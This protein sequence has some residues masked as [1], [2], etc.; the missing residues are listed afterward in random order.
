[1]DEVEDPE[2]DNEAGDPEEEPE[3]EEAD[4]EDEAVDVV[5]EAVL[6]VWSFRS[7]NASNISASSRLL[8]D[9]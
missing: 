2:E 1:V 5:A 7:M 4:P 6:E 3:V 9:V 8:K